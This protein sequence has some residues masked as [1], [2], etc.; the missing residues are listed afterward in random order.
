MA[1]SEESIVNLAVCGINALLRE[2][3]VEFPVDVSDEIGIG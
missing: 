3:E 1:F 2:H